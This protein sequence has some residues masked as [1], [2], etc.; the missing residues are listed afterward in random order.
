METVAKKVYKVFK[1]T[2][3]NDRDM[4]HFNDAFD[5]YDFEGIGSHGPA[6]VVMGS[7]M[8]EVAVKPEP[9][10]EVVVPEVTPEGA[11]SDDVA[12]VEGQKPAKVVD[13][14]RS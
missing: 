14:F 7:R 4:E 3:T 13:P 8:E 1:M 9:E 5:G 12:E 6:I 2:T 10:P 11:F